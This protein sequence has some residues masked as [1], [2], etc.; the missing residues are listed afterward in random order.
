MAEESVVVWDAQPISVFYARII[1][2][3]LPM[4]Q[5]S[6][7]THVHATFVREDIIF[8][9]ANEQTP[10]RRVTTGSHKSLRSPSLHVERR[11]CSGVV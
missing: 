8:S 7:E 3:E 2:S 4:M 11:P 6:S 9:C 5:S 1:I 10:S